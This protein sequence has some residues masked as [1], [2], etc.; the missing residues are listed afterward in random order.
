MTDR[1]GLIVVV[2]II[3]LLSPKHV[4]VADVIFITEDRPHET[5]RRE[6]SDLH[7]TVDIFLR[8][9]LTGTVV[10]V[11]TLDDRTLRIPLTSVITP[12]YKKRILGEGLPL[13]ENPKGKGDLIITFNIEYPVYMPVSNKNY[14]KRA[15]DT[16]EDIRDTEYVHRLILANK[17]RRNIDFDVPVRRDPKDYEAKEL[18]FICNI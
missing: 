2:R 9:A 12:D 18:D 13:P 14:V 1:N 8:E 16:S 4:S 10:T 11:D 7:M 3:S 15:F 5:F 6:G 17:M